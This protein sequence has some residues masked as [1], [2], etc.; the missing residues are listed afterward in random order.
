MTILLNVYCKRSHCTVKLTGPDDQGVS[1]SSL[2][3]R[4]SKARASGPLA[5]CSGHGQK[6][7]TS[8]G[9]CCPRPRRTLDPTRS[10]GPL[11]LNRYR[12]LGAP[13]AHRCAL[14]GRCALL[15]WSVS[16]ANAYPRAD[17]L[18]SALGAST[19]FGLFRTAPRA[20]TRF[21]GSLF[22]TASPLLAEHGVD[23]GCA[24]ARLGNGRAHERVDH[25]GGGPP[26]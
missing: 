13:H 4:Q 8:G 12:S 19:P 24:R 5:L 1:S 17:R 16:R 3:Q 25:R 20:S 9:P 18:P 7:S 10:S 15:V 21:H 26:R 23:G 2:S 22:Q 14:P 6:L 11:P